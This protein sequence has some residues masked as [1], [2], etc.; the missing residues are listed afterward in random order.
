MGEGKE[1]SL[2]D[3][4]WIRGGGFAASRCRLGS[5]WNVGG[6]V[7]CVVAAG[8]TVT[9][10]TLRGAVPWRGRRPPQRG[11]GLL[12]GQLGQVVAT[13][14]PRALCPR[15]PSQPPAETEACLPIVGVLT[16]L[17]LT[18]R[19]IR[20][21]RSRLYRRHER[22]LADTRAEQIEEKCQLVDKLYAAKKECALVG[23]SL[24][25]ARRE[26]GPVKVPG[27]AAAHSKVRPDST[28]KELTPVA[29]DLNGARAGPPRP[30]TGT[31]RVPE[32]VKSLQEVTGATTP[33]G[34]SPNLLGDQEPSPGGPSP[35][36]GL[37]LRAPLNPPLKAWAWAWASEH[38]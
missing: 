16:G 38:R 21:L 4:F 14:L 1:W 24:E 29:R 31:A 15:L 36:V 17:F 22:W 10:R 37:G 12:L 33:P 5:G 30:E 9:G 7:G 26:E 8:P 11:V 18:L 32:V 27:P 28:V 2:E 25:N 6:S 13:L 19:L 3:I 20:A 34:A 35:G 23:K